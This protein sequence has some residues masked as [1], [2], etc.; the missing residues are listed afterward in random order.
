M[1][2]WIF[3]HNHN[4]K[5]EEEEESGEQQKFEELCHQL[6]TSTICDKKGVVPQLCPVLSNFDQIIKLLNETN[7]TKFLFESEDKKF[8][9]ILNVFNKEMILSS[10]SAEIQMNSDFLVNFC[11]KTAVYY[12]IVKNC[13]KKVDSELNKYRFAFDVRFFLIEIKVMVTLIKTL[14]DSTKSVLPLDLRFEN[15]FQ[16]FFGYI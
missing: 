3:C 16:L 14:V 12:K 6:S 5:E 11:N 4:R 8:S 15:D 2:D 13:E 7:D 1:N 10:I 9:L